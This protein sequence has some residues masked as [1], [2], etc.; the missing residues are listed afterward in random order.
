MLMSDLLF[1]DTAIIFY[2]RY[3]LWVEAAAR[4]YYILALNLSVPLFIH[5]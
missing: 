1:L 2:V 5:S 4:I 3:K